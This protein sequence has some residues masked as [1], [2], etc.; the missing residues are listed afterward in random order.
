PSPEGWTLIINQ[1]T[2]QAGTEYDEGRDLVRVAMQTSQSTH[3]ERF[4]I[5]IVTE[6]GGGSI[7]LRWGTVEA[8]VPF[9]LSS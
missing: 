4:T 2:G 6:G 8:A 3:T 5:D 7:V 1:Q 9:R